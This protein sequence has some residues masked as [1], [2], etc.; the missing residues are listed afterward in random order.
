MKGGD[1]NDFG[2]FLSRLGNLHD[3]N[4]TRFDWKPLQNWIGFEIDD[5]YFN[6]E[7]LPEYQGPLPGRIELED[8]QHV[9]VRLDSIVGPLRIYD[10]LVRN[11]DSGTSVVSVTFW[12]HGKIEVAYRRAV[13]PSIAL[14]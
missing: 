7:G 8:V 1:M 6:F 9:A 10:F 4:V 13:F 2:G 3:C 12:P 11:Q 14:P 5:L